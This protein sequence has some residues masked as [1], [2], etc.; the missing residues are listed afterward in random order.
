MR[1]NSHETSNWIQFIWISI[2]AEKS[3]F[4]WNIVEESSIAI[5]YS[6]FHTSVSAITNVPLVI[7]I[8]TDSRYSRFNYQTYLTFQFVHHWNNKLSHLSMRWNRCLDSRLLKLNIQNSADILHNFTSEWSAETI[9]PNAQTE[10]KLMK[11]ILV[12]YLTITIVKVISV[13]IEGI[14]G[15]SNLLKMRLGRDEKRIEREF[16]GRNFIKHMTKLLETF[17]PFRPLPIVAMYSVRHN[18]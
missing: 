1:G 7:T 14:E 11:T 17:V 6:Y 9:W 12:S 16:F 13:E 4:N 15:H 8:Y 3:Q 10:W 5:S 2:S 18:F